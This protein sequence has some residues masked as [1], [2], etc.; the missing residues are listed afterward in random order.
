MPKII[1]PGEEALLEVPAELVTGGDSHDHVGGDGAQIDH[2][3]LLNLLTGDPHTQ[4]HNGTRHDAH[5][6]STA[7]GTAVLGDLSDA[8][9]WQ[10]YTPTYQNLTVGNGTVFAEYW[11]AGKLV[12]VS[13]RF[14][15]GSTSSVGTNVRVSFPVTP[16]GV[17]NVTWWPHGLAAFH[18]VGVQ[19]LFGK[20]I[21]DSGWMSPRV[22]NTAGT[23]ESMTQVSATVPFTWADAPNDEMY[24]QA[25]YQAA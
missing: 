2:A 14:I 16:G 6:H 7:L 3:G 18:E 10:T 8:S 1:L 25:V 5:D 23:Y 12:V 4:Y 15:M 21:H 13:W 9:D 19:V 22:S 20:V 17:N 24:L 11:K